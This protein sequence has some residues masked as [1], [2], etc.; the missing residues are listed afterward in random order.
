MGVEFGIYLVMTIESKLRSVFF[1]EKNWSDH[2]LSYYQ[3]GLSDLVMLLFPIHSP[4]LCFAPDYA[5][6]KLVFQH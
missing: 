5:G 3:I 1:N 2:I 6:I 4:S